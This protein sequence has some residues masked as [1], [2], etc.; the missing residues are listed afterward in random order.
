MVD[1]LDA[2]FTLPP[3]ATDFFQMKPG[4][5][6]ETGRRAFRTAL[7]AAARA[8]NGQVGEIGEQACPRTFHTASVTH[9]AAYF[10][11]LCHAHHP[12]IAFTQERR[13]W[14][15]DK[16]VDPPPWSHPFTA[17]GFVVLT[18]KQLVT[19]LSEVASS[20]LSQAEWRQVRY[21]GVTTMGGML[22]N[23]WD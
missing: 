7:Y 23:A 21:H 6:P 19:P 22:F 1:A 2:V 8:A 16:F 15:T 3:G 11:V 20:S 13:D 5:F 18:N 4:P 14:Y 10:V 17:A 9:D 12:W